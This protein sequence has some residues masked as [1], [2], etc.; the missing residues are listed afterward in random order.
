M[1]SQDNIDNNFEELKETKKKSQ[2]NGSQCAAAV[3][4]ILDEDNIPTF[5][6]VL[7]D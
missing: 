7:K 1:S 2:E 3:E 4:I 6:D 5:D